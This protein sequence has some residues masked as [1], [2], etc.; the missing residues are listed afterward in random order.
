MK[1]TYDPDKNKINI[2][3]HGISLS[4]TEAV[5]YDPFAIVKEDKDHDE[6]RLV[7]IGTGNNGV[8][9]TVCYTYKTDDEI[10]VISARK[11]SK[12]ERKHYEE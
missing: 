8:V 7:A 6:S 1:L 11:A 3:K 4:E 12:G 2:Q 5:F 10:R 9:L